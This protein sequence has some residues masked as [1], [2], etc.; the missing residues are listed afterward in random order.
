MNLE[1][2]GELAGISPGLVDFLASKQRIVIWW[3][4][5]RPNAAGMMKSEELPNII[6]DSATETMDITE[7]AINSL[8]RCLP[9]GLSGKTVRLGAL[10]AAI[11][12]LG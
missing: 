1:S 9:A 10:V 4:T 6:R 12:G 11:E 7:E 8:A 2:A 3:I 5:V